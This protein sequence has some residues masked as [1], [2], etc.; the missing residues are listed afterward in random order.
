MP[1]VAV[2]RLAARLNESWAG[3]MAQGT[4][5]P[6]DR[7]ELAAYADRIKGGEYLKA[8]AQSPPSSWLRCSR[9]RSGGPGN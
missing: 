5:E 4:F 7:P 3:K 8:P 6:G 9:P 2:F 1:L